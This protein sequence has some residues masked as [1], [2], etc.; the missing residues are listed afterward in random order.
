[1]LRIGVLEARGDG[2]PSWSERLREAGHPARE[3]RA[4]ASATGL[5][6]V[7]LVDASAGSPE[8]MLPRGGE[9]RRPPLVVVADDARADLWLAAGA[10][11]VLRPDVGIARAVTELRLAVRASEH[12]RSARDDVLAI[13]AHD[14]RSPLSSITLQAAAMRRAAEKAGDATAAKRAASIGST[15]RR[16][17]RLI[18]GL[19]DAAGIEAGAVAL[20]AEPLD[21]RALV[22]EV[23]ELLAPAA[24]AKRVQ[25]VTAVPPGPVDVR[26]DC[27]RVLQ[28]LANLVGNAVKFT[29]AGGRV[30]VR[31]SATDAEA[32]I[33]VSDT[34]CGIAP[35]RVRQIFERFVRSEPSDG[36]GSGLGLY[37]ARGLTEA[38]RGTISV[39]SA[40]RAGSRFSV[41]LPRALGDRTVPASLPGDRA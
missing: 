1:M 15:A 32:R 21:A 29:P 3:L 27:D 22:D 19:L 25:L 31:L 13:V 17:D 38:H 6:V 33:D 30:D 20:N 7:L 34:G 28:I 16:M 12:A 23:A 41:R 9:E 36:G 5:D 4:G 10:E 40:E 35:D 39:E 37:I 2:G 18:Q 14:L 26:W 24:R 8:P 11:R